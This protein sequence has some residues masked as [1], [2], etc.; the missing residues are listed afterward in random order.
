[1]SGEPTLSF[2][3]CPVATNLDDTYKP[4]AAALVIVTASTLRS[5]PLPIAQ[6]LILLSRVFAMPVPLSVGETKIWSPWG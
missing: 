1:M 5:Q 6:V 3:S 2:P 4:P